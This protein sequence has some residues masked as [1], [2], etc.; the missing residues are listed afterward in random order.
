M[1]SYIRMDKYAD[2]TLKPEDKCKYW[3]MYADGKP[4]PGGKRNQKSRYFRGG[5]RAMLKALA[6]FELEVAEQSG[7]DMNFAD[8]LDDWIE[9]REGVVSPSTL[10]RD[11]QMRGILKHYFGKYKLSQITTDICDEMYL[12]LKQN[13][14]LTGKIVKSS[15]IAFIQSELAN[16]LND[17]VRRG[18]LNKSPL[19]GALRE[20]KKAAERT[21]PGSDRV[22]EMLSRLDPRNRHQMGVMLCAVL[23]LRRGEA[24]GL[25]FGDITFSTK[26]KPGELH[27]RHSMTV[28]YILK[29]PKTPHSNR[30]L[31]L[32]D[33]LEESI[34]IR[35]QQVEAD[36][37]MSF[38]AKI[39]DEVPNIN[40][41]WVL[42]DEYGNCTGPIALSNWWEHHRKDYG[43]KSSL[44]DLRHAFL[45]TLAERGV[46]PRVM[47]DFAGHATPSMTLEI[48]SHANMKMK[49]D[50]FSAVADLLAPKTA[51]MERL[52]E[53]ELKST[54]EKANKSDEV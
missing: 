42:S 28:D 4:K 16:V 44:H 14:G 19:V 43:I 51:E 1:G 7:K 35:K 22:Q 30:R 37:A 18:F 52:D 2:G 8:Y 48:Y 10:K 21:P 24:C 39:I 12:D 17:A 9:R 13:G 49:Q 27:V 53:K 54:L 47:M 36:L 3:R 5:K 29:D 26:N 15:Y 45:T 33:F 6:A 38:K 50:A 34:K 32:S 25:K 31:P 40:D 11:K 23:G 20:K 41:V 46:H